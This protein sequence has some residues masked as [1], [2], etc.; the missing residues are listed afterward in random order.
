MVG[1]T[2][3]FFSNFSKVQILNFLN[4]TKT[5][6]RELVSHIDA[7]PPIW[8]S[9]YILRRGGEDTDKNMHKWLQEVDSN[10]NCGPLGPAMKEPPAVQGL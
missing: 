1:Y 10:V 7:L 8:C 5:S 2:L 3:V 4:F 6:S 9:T